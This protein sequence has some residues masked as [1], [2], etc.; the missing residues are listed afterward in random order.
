MDSETNLKRF[1]LLSG[2]TY[3]PAPG[4]LNFNSWHNSIEEALAKWKE[5]VGGESSCEWCQVLDTATFKIVA[6]V[7]SGHT[8]LFGKVQAGPPTPRT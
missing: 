2:Q 1:A 8:G 3:Y 5:D 4:W 7:G 6:G